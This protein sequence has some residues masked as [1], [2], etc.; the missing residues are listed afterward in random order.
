MLIFHH[1]QP[2]L[3]QD[4]QSTHCTPRDTSHARGVGKAK[5]R[6]VYLLLQDMLISPGRTGVLHPCPQQQASNCKFQQGRG[7]DDHITFG[8]V[9]HSML[10]GLCQGH[11]QAS[12]ESTLCPFASCA[13]HRTVFGRL[14]GA[15]PEL[16]AYRCPAD[17]EH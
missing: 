3:P 2:G 11:P 12:V 7:A 13:M 16:V 4:Q 5:R 14:A 1:F 6:W 15:S 17:L 8:S 9:P 10:Y